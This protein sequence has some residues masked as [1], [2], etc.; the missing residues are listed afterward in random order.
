M[1]RRPTFRLGTKYLLG[2]A[3]V[4]AVMGLF[5]S[6]AVQRRFLRA[7]RAERERSGTVATRHL[8]DV[9]VGPVLTEDRLALADI[10]D[11]Y[12][13][14]DPNIVYI[15]IHDYRGGVVTHTFDHAFPQA[16]LVDDVGVREEPHVRYLDTEDGRIIDVGVP[17]LSGTIGDAHV[18][19]SETRFR[20]DVDDLAG[21]VSR[22]IIA[23]MIAGGAFMFLLAHLLSRPLSE[24]REAARRLGQGDLAGK[25][26]VRTSD[27]IGQ[28]A[29]EFNRM[30]DNLRASDDKIRAAHTG[31]QRTNDDQARINRILRLSFHSAALETVLESALRIVLSA[32][33]ARGAG[34]AAIF[35]TAD[36]GRALRLLAAVGFARDEKICERT[37]AGHC[38]CGRAALSKQTLFVSAD[39]DEHATQNPG[40]TARAHY[41]VPIRA[42]GR[43]LGLL[44]VHLAPDRERDEE[45]VQFLEALAH[46]LAAV[47]QKERSERARRKANVQL[48]QIMGAIGSALIAVDPTG[49]VSAW[50]PEAV[51]LFGLPPSQ[52]IGHLLADLAIGWDLPAVQACLTEC[53]VAGAHRT[54][55]VALNR[56]GASAEL[57]IEVT[58]N[59]MHDS[60][61][62]RTGHLLLVRDPTERVV[63]AE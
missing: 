23:S 54:V 42:G 39:D 43:A 55:E 7:Q 27:E 21:D 50:N 28:L 59:P 17:L 37:E 20:R 8:A 58:V 26:P 46:A 25:V 15:F 10:I 16:L 36:H 44:N 32:P 53:D 40:T 56:P 51:E 41:C 4:V 1:K 18:G 19:Y 3:L 33:L 12:Q 63:P 34:G 47:L 45:D 30:A 6:T 52:A 60:Q 61:Q 31:L 24:L 13:T 22:L 5:I 48:R 9:C 49:R 57:R 38:L 62:R 2:T 11:D 35:E 29:A 14:A